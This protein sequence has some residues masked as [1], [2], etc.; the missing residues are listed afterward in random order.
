MSRRLTFHD[1]AEREISDA[2]A[3][4][5]NSSPGLG[6]SFIDDVEIAVTQ[7]ERYRVWLPFESGRPQ[8]PSSPFSLRRNVLGKSRR[9]QDLGYR[10][11][12]APALLLA[13]PQ[14]GHP[15]A[16]P[17][18]PAGGNR[19]W[20]EPC[21]GPDEEA[22]ETRGGKNGNAAIGTA[23]DPICL[24]FQKPLKGERCVN[25]PLAHRRWPSWIRSLTEMSTRGV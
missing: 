18:S 15:A 9:D 25:Y 22:P 4:Y 7:I 6:N 19:G 16:C 14:V 1:A 3:Y 21:G 13:R 10:Q 11:S 12:Q 23:G 17:P 2:A 24:V 20:N 5:D 8:S